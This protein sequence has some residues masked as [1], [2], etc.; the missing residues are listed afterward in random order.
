VPE[1][2]QRKTLHTLAQMH[3]YLYAW[4]SQT[5]KSIADDL[6]LLVPSLPTDVKALQH[7]LDGLCVV[8]SRSVGESVNEFV[9]VHRLHDILAIRCVRNE[10]ANRWTKWQSPRRKQRGKRQSDYFGHTTLLECEI[11]L[12][13]IDEHGLRSAL[14][15]ALKDSADYASLS[16]GYYSLLPFGH[17]FELDPTNIVWLLANKPEEQRADLWMAVDWLRLIVF[18]KKHAHYTKLLAQVTASL[19]N[20]LTRIVRMKENNPRF[21]ASRALRLFGDCL[22]Q[23]DLILKNNL[24]AATVGYGN[25]LKDTFG[26]RRISALPNS[27][28]FLRR[29]QGQ[30]RLSNT[31][32]RKQ[33]ENLRQ[34]FNDISLPDP[35]SP[36]NGPEQVFDVFLCHNS[37]DKPEVR[38]VAR[39]LKTSG[40]RP[41][42]DEEQ[43]RPGLPWQEALEEQISIIRAAAV[44]VGA[45][46]LGPWQTMELRAF[47]N[48]FV[49]RRCPV[50]PV[51]LWSVSSPPSLP[52]F[53]RNLTWVDFRKDSV[54]A[55][56]LLIWGITNN[57]PPGLDA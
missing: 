25:S 51:L 15:E 31:V 26:V 29:L 52:L 1:P 10:L 45:S 30:L 43:L 17:L 9:Y 57:R 32:Y 50:I 54:R 14:G 56:K 42:L 55:L 34:R 27:Q 13:D 21:N 47:L 22:R 7:V 49:R 44:F 40:V 28:S 46:N 12:Y 41:W 53:L 18:L 8:D 35:P 23:G 36:P 2:D 6:H 3:V 5:A 4:E 20:D 11:D 24:T 48:E 37:I 19:E 39:L 33:L 16:L 38:E